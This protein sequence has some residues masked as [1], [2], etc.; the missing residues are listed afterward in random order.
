MIVTDISLTKPLHFANINCAATILGIHVN[1]QNVFPEVSNAKD[2]IG[3]Y[4]GIPLVKTIYI[5]ESP[6]E[7]NPSYFSFFLVYFSYLLRT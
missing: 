1:A 3:G 6:I 2:P 4:Q 5:P 7:H